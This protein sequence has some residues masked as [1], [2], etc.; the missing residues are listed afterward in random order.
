VIALMR[1]EAFG[2]FLMTF[3]A[4]KG[5]RAGSELVAR[6]ALRRAVEG[7]MR[8]RERARGNL[9]AS[10]DGAEQESAEYQQRTEEPTRRNRI[11]ADPQARC[12]CREKR[13]S[14]LRQTVRCTSTAV[15]LVANRQIPYFPKVSAYQL[16][17]SSKAGP[18][19][20]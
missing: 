16:C 13:H 2:N 4:L 5:W 6:V 20:R 1:G 10:C 12:F 9:G 11:D 15:S 18:K 14:S 19:Y 7:L 17:S 8:F 3:Q